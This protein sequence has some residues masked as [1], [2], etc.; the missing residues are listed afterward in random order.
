MLSGNEISDCYGFGIYISCA[1]GGTVV[2]DYIHDNTITDCE[3][4]IGIICQEKHNN[5]QLCEPCRILG[6]NAL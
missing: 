4:G 1:A 5:Q 6:F 3:E 2:N